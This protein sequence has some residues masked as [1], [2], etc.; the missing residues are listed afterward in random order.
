MQPSPAGR[1]AGYTLKEWDWSE[2]PI[3]VLVVSTMLSVSKGAAEITV[4]NWR[5]QDA[6]RGGCQR[7]RHEVCMCTIATTKET[8]GRREEE[9]EESLRYL[10]LETRLS[11]NKHW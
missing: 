11:T 8:T 10:S 7:V 4:V 5:W 9:E 3:L 1:K 2:E 6:E